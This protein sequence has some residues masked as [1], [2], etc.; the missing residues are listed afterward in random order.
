MSTARANTQPPAAMATPR[1]DDDVPTPQA[2]QD[3]RR[4]PPG[5]AGWESRDPQ[6]VTNVSR[7]AALVVRAQVPSTGTEIVQRY[8]GM[9][10]HAL[11]WDMGAKYVC[12]NADGEGR[13]AVCRTFGYRCCDNP[14]DL[15][16]CVI[17]AVSWG[18]GL[19]IITVGVLGGGRSPFLLKVDE[20]PPAL[21]AAVA[22]EHRAIFED[23]LGW[24]S[25]ALEVPAEW[26]SPGWALKRGAE[27]GAEPGAESGTGGD[28]G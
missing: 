12:T 11:E 14:L 20:Y 9:R 15:D 5:G 23:P 19:E 28:A 7:A 8:P 1:T 6:T 13:D 2:V 17:A 3:L 25:H 16:C 24:L 21:L 10:S 22:P 4:Y 18:P 26:G 27:S